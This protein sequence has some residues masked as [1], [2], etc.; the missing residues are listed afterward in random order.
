MLSKNFRASKLSPHDLRHTAACSLLA[1]FQSKN[2][3]MT[4]SMNQLR[5]FMGWSPN[6]DMPCRYARL[7]IQEQAN[8]TA[9]TALNIRLNNMYGGGK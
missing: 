8:S 4:K 9:S 6:S 7:Y 5:E 2:N 3:D 1:I